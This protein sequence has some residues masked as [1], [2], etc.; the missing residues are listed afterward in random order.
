M[1]EPFQVLGC[2]LLEQLHYKPGQRHY[3]S[4]PR[5]SWLHSLMVRSLGH[6]SKLSALRFLIYKTW[7]VT[8]PKLHMADVNIK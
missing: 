3:W 7:E 4:Q 6:I 2:L 1:G 5:V 8:V